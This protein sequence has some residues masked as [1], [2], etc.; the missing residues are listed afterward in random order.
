MDDLKSVSICLDS[1]L[2]GFLFVFWLMR[3]IMVEDTWKATDP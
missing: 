3:L 1:V 2:T